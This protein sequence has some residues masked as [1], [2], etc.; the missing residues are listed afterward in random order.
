MLPLEIID[1]VRER[2]RDPIAQRPSPK[3][4][5]ARALDE[6]QNAVQTANNLGDAWAIGEFTLTAQAGIRRYEITQMDF[7]KPLLVATVPADDYE[8]ELSLEFTQVEQ[9][10]KDWA[11]LKDVGNW[12]LLWQWD[13]SHSA[14]YVAFWRALEAKGYKYY[15]ELRPVPTKAE[16]Y[17]ILYQVGEWASKLPEDLDF[18]FPLREL[19]FYFTALVALGVLDDTRWSRDE[20]ADLRR[21]AQI[22]ESLLFD[23]GRYK[24]TFDNYIA[25]L[26]QSQTVM[27]ESYADYVGLD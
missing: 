17:R 7:G 6:Y 16:D 3:R 24:E 22:K 5:L 2:L 10:P 21:A 25:S 18:A 1:R 15:C 27:A 14:R 9:L 19:D 23:L 11:W 26:S 8:R 12:G 4:I 20:A 13:V